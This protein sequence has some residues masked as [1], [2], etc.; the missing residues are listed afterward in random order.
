MRNNGTKA[1]KQCC[2]R[3]GNGSLTVQSR[4]VRRELHGACPP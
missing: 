2:H 3:L 1:I 4:S